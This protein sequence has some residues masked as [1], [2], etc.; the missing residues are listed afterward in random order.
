VRSLCNSHPHTTITMRLI[1]AKAWTLRLKRGRRTVLVFADPAAPLLRVKESLLAALRASPARDGDG[2]DAPEEPEPLPA[3]AADIELARPVD[4]FDVTAGFEMIGSS[5]AE[6]E[7]DGDG[8]AGGDE[9]E[10][11]END[12]EEEEEQNGESAQPGGTSTSAR[13]RRSTAQ[14]SKSDGMSLTSLGIKDNAVLVY[15]FRSGGAKKGEK[16]KDPGWSI[17]V[18]SFEDAYGVENEGDLGVKPEFRG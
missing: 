8:E 11:D 15:R 1:P 9:K 2:D 12:E 13:G 14:K 5:E 16:S 4:V 17:E 6:D 18:P 3:A 7:T 10:R